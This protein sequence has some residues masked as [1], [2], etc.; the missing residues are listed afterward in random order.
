MIKT[1]RVDESTHAKLQK[2]IGLMKFQGKTCADTNYTINYLVTEYLRKN[3][4]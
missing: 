4:Q 3:K 2:V 1:L